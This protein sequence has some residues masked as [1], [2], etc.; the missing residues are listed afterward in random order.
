M[1]MADTMGI[2]FVILG[3]MLA[4]PGLW[5][6]CRGLWPEA[7]TAAATR[8]HKGFWPSLLVGLL[9]TLAMIVTT[10]VLFSVLGPLGKIGGVGLVCLYML[11][12]HT[13]V[14]GF[15]TSIGSRIASP[16]DEERPWRATLR[17]GVVLELAYLLP[18][19]GWFVI[20]PASII[21]GCGA[22]TL[23]LASKLKDALLPAP[24]ASG[25]AVNEESTV[26]HV[27][28]PVGVG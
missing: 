25:V 26:G 9:P 5:L 7:V 22:A 8:C 15:A 3:M 18:F 12:A 19:L 6:L 11:H 24:V 17:G 14:S 23:V 10:K 20:L 21:I 27:S 13:G 16:V 28:G 2:F 1:L 4:F